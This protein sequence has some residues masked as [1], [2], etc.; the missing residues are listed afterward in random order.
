[1]LD[2]EDIYSVDLEI[3]S[4]SFIPECVG[5]L[6]GSFASKSKS[7]KFKDPFK[8]FLYLPSAGYLMTTYPHLQE[9]ILFLE[10]CLLGL[11]ITLTPFGGSIS[12]FFCLFFFVGLLVAS[13]HTGGNM[14]CLGLWSEEG[15]SGPHVHSIHFMFSLGAFLAPVVSGPFLSE[16]GDEHGGKGEKFETGITVLYPI[17]GENLKKVF[18]ARTSAKICG[19]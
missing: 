16:R 13:I 19:L 7:M 4:L 10:L 12:V 18:F 14:L 17:I 1:M 11:S 2:L 8:T 5:S 3:I 9:L 6:A 15:E